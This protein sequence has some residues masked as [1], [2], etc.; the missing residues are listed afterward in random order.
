MQKPLW[1]FYSCPF[2]AEYLFALQ[3]NIFANLAAA[4]WE[5]SVFS[6]IDKLHSTDLAQQL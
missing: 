4:F 2:S 6:S 1:S 3:P 5:L